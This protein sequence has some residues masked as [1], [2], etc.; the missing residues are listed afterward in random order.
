M[1]QITLNNN[2]KCAIDGPP[3]ELVDLR[4]SLKF[5]HPNSH[6]VRSYMPKG[7]DG[8]VYSITEAGYFKTGLL[9]SV[10]DKCEELGF[11]YK[12]KD[13]RGVDLNPKVPKK[14]GDLEP[15]AYQAEAVKKILNNKIAGINFPIG[16]L[17]MATN[18]GKTL[19]MAMIYK[20]YKNKKAIMLINDGDLFQQFERE[21]PNLIDSQ[22]LGFIRGKNI[23]FGN[24]TIAMVQTLS[25]KVK[26]YINELA[27]FDIC[28]VDE[29]DLSDNKTYKTIISH[30][31]NAS[32]RVGLSGTIYMSNLSKDKLKNHNLESYLGPV[33]SKITKREMMD[34]GYSTEIVVKIVKGNTS[35]QKEFFDYLSAYKALITNNPEVYE[36]CTERLNLNMK[37]NRLPALVICQ[38]K[39]H[40]E[41]LCKYLKKQY[42]LLRVEY[43][44]SG[45]KDKI[46]ADI[47]NRFREGNIDILVS[48][49][50]VK[51]GKNF[52]LIRY[53][54][55]AGGSDSNATISQLMGRGE[56]THD[57]KKKVVMDD[58]YHKGKYIE[59]H[60]KH[61]I[62]YYKKE[63]IR[64]IKL[65]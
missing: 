19:M 39:D 48:S 6:W 38:F 23:K 8:M 7:W 25:P 28:L 55:N 21:L 37:L 29:A 41:K 15:R 53:I 30:L 54:L 61:R 64:V 63:Q 12:I 1:I 34:L 22:E 40:T 10:T 5:K 33:L 17:D 11:K 46:R 16:V 20:S 32:I 47:S 3:Q 26:L 9:K 43:M 13:N 57:S 27:K 59:R 18:A 36:K 31:F 50:V 51:R 4:K 60:S 62:N 42:P 14:V 2:N 44:H 45:L 35:N 58:M 56:R 49:Y 52:P 24:F 65:V